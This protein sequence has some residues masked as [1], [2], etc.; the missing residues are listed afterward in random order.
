MSRQRIVMLGITLAMVFCIV[1]FIAN[2][3]V[4]NTPSTHIEI[5]PDSQSVAQGETFSVDIYVDAST[6]NL[7]AVSIDLY[8]NSTVFSVNS[9]TEG[10][11]FGTPV[12][13]EPG[14]GIIT[15][16][17][18]HYG[19]TRAS[20]NPAVPASGVFITVEFSVDASAT[21]GMYYTL[22]LEDDLR[23]EN[24]NPIPGVTINDG[25]TTVTETGLPLQVD[26]DGPYS[27]TV[28]VPI[29]FFGSA[30]GGTPP[31]SYEWDFGDGNASNEQNPTHKYS[32]D[33]T[34]TVKLTVEDDDGA[35]DTKSRDI[36][37][38]NVKPT[39]NFNYTPESPVKPD[40]T[41]EFTD[42]SID[43]DGSIVNWSWDFGDGM[44]GYGSQTTHTYNKTG[45]YDV[46]LTVTDDDGDTDKYTATI[47]VEKEKTPGLEFAFLIIAIASIILFK[48]RN[49]KDR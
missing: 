40:A 29:Q 46:T 6:H 22:D 19:M 41:I 15:P 33:E 7:K 18:I 20:G 3:E 30:S 32:D 27:G 43:S 4:S 34:Y 49:N 2:M 1:F 38:K 47:K 11:L 44:M 8:Y 23:D 24:N 25:T 36:T 9:I 14:S 13:V 42:D 37:I 31:Y 21:P 16:G 10:T 12:L 45:S 26:A 35:T 39:S 28:G 48:R 17:H 5:Q